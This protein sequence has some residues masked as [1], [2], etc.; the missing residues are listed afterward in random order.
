MNVFNL[1]FR[2]KSK[3]IKRNVDV[4]I[5]EGSEEVESVQG[6]S[7][8]LSEDG[9]IDRVR[10]QHQR[11]H[12]CCG[13]SAEVP[14]GGKCSVCSQ[15]ACVKHFG[16]CVECGAAICNLHSRL[17]ANSGDERVC[18]SCTDWLAP[19]LAMQKIFGLL[20]GK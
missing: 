7:W 15:V 4:L 20:R 18:R 1:L 13:C 6:E 19:K 11:F 9:S 8:N 2:E 12:S 17:R 16:N 10:I 5:S 3:P 14:V